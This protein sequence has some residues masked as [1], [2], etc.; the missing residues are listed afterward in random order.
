M[1]EGICLDTDILIEIINGNKTIKEISEFKKSEV[2]CTTS[3]N[4]FELWL[5]EKEKDTLKLSELTE[6]L[7]VFD[8]ERES[9]K[10]AA[11]ILRKL[12]NEGKLIEFRD[13]FIGA[14]CI[15]NNLRLLT[16]NKKDFKRLEKFNLNLV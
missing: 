13:I 2:L 16:L 1:D 11:N 12:K 15:K 7:F 14:I 9:A 10:I 5:G 3:I 6:E 4:V 8:F